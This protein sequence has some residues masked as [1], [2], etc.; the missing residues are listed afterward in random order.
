MSLEDFLQKTRSLFRSGPDTPP[1]PTKDTAVVSVLFIC[2][3]NLCRS[4]MAEGVLRRMLEEAGLAGKVYVQS[5]GTHSYRV[6][7]M[8][9]PRGLQAAAR[10]GADLRG[11]RSRRVTVE[12]IAAFDYVLVMDQDNFE[13][14]KT[15][16]PLPDEQAKIKL[17]LDFAPHLPEREVPD[18]YYGGLSGFERVL[19]LLEE[20]SRG[21][22]QHLRR[23]HPL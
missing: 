2:M 12:D 10:R 20:A 9:D 16:I 15:L 22:I 17:F 3:G 13:F 11:I 8:P 4:P 6:G 5:A 1:L 14:L 7:V 19:D 18:P 23:H 21:L